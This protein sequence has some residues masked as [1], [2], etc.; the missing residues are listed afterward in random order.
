M[1]KDI[2]NNIIGSDFWL[3][4]EELSFP[5]ITRES[6]IPDRWRRFDMIDDKYKALFLKPINT[7]VSEL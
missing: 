6:R 1:I 3:N 7:Y 2:K 4:S 5:E